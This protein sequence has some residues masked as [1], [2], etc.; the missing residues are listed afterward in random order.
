MTELNA[1]TDDLMYLNILDKLSC[2][3][4][5]NLL[6]SKRAFTRV[7]RDLV[8]KPFPLA[9]YLLELKLTAIESVVSIIHVLDT[10]KFMLTFINENKMVLFVS[11][12][13][14][15]N[16]LHIIELTNDDPNCLSITKTMPPNITVIKGIL[17]SVFEKLQ[18]VNVDDF[19]KLYKN[20]KK[21]KLRYHDGPDLLSVR[22]FNKL[23]MT[24]NA[25]IIGEATTITALRRPLGVLHRA[26]Y[27][28]KR[29]NEYEH[30]LTNPN[31]RQGNPDIVHLLD[32]GEYLTIFIHEDGYINLFVHFAISSAVYIKYDTR[33]CGYCTVNLMAFTIE[34]DGRGGRFE[35]DRD[36]L[37][38][39]L[40]KAWQHA[41][42]ICSVYRDGVLNSVVNGNIKNPWRNIVQYPKMCVCE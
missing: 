22:N 42:S 26:K 33:N 5:I 41:Y 30:N 37:L 31:H 12:D 32:T 7:S 15:N 10:Y 23:E 17:N 11:N 38:F 14:V 21:I 27:E 36:F 16:D 28:M 35:N 2:N 29:R 4:A 19:T 25:N 1:L 39:H 8:T 9:L 20:N 6:Q 3:D 40:T 34:P 18:F 24:Q 13:R